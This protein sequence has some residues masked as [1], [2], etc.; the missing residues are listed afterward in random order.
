MP[1]PPPEWVKALTPSSPQGTDLLKQERAQ[2]NVEVDKLAE[3]LHT[4]AFLEKQQRFLE[5]LSSEKVFDKSQMHS[6]GRPERIQR[7][8]A[9]GKRLQ[10]LKE[11]YNWSIEDYHFASEMIGEP[12]PYGLHASM[13]L[14]TLRE[15]CTPEQKKLFLEPAEKYQIIGCYAQ[16]ELGHGSNVR[17]LETTATW[18]PE[19]KTFTIHSPS[20]TASKWWIGSLGRTANHAVVMAQLFIAGKNYGPHPF[21]VQIRDLETHQPLENI[22]VGDIGPKFG[23]NTMDNGFLLFNN[24]KIPHINMLARFSRVDEE[25]NKYM[26]PA[27]PALVFGTMTWVRSS[28]VLQA[29]SVLARGVTIATRYCAVRRQ[30]QDRDAKADAG[31]TQVLNYKMVQV[32]LLPLL[33][34]MYALH[35]TGRGMM[36]LY[37]ENQNKRA[38]AEAGQ[39]KRGAAPEALRAGSDLLADL[40]ATSCGLKALASTTAG[41]GLEICRRACGGHGYSSYSGIGPYYS[42][43]LPTLTWEGDNYMLTQQVARYLLKSARAVLA[44]KGTGNDTSQI[45]QAYLARRDKGA[46]FDILEVDSDIVAAFAWRTAH[47]TFEALKHRDLEKRSWNSLLVDFWR[48]STAHSQYLVVKNF[49][50][51]VSSPEL[52]AKLGP[53]TTKI[54]HNLFRLYALHTLERE[55]A[56]FFSSGAVTVRQITLTRTN[57]VMKLLDE[58]RPHAV[59]L[60]DAWKIPD[61]QLDSSLGRYDGDVYP[62]LFNRASQNPVNDLVFD[63][64]PWNEAVL[65]NA[66][67]SKL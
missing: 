61:W 51:A 19:D 48:L 33:A 4:K 17:G 27:S 1:S 26:R 39:D 23:Y 20:L 14:V 25:T 21:I 13:F 44:G 46:S 50:E 38:A 22:Y 2:S 56:E 15:Q 30:F 58:I 18:N 60:V 42:D 45:L 37:E 62:D 28:I 57:A 41:E 40:H 31:E 64:Y 8:L 47:L 66:P 59:R 67:K 54:M 49:Y 52:A 63:P 12:T 35:F 24:V 6:L 43:Y 32:R 65:K 11:K 5:L 29:G 16:T 53:E 3:F 55:A 10:Q 9:K 36:R 34:A 7:A